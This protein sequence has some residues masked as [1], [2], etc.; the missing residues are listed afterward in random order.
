MYIALSSEVTMALSLSLGEKMRGETLTSGKEYAHH[1]SIRAVKTIEFFNAVV[2][3][4]L[5]TRGLLCV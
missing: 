2:F 5:I 1:A 3:S 4:Y